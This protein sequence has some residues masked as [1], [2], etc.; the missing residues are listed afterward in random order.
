MQSPKFWYNSPGHPGWQARLLAPIGRVYAAATARRVAAAKGYQSQVPVV[1][2]GN[3]NIGGTGKTPSVIALAQHLLE[4]G[5]NPHV[6][7]RGY[8]GTLTGPVRVDEQ[9]H[10]ASE[11]G[12][13]PLLIA[14]FAPVW[15][16]DNRADGV[17]AA[18]KAGADIIILDDGFQSPAVHYDMS[19]IVVDAVRGFG[20]GRCLPAGPLREPVQAGM[21]RADMVLSIG[22]KKA[23]DGFRKAWGGQIPVPHVTGELTPLPTGF[24]WAGQDVIAFAGI[25]HPEKFFATLRDLGANVVR[26]EALNDHQVLSDALLTRLEAEALLCDAQLVTTEKDAVRLPA[27]FRPKVVTLP[28]RLELADWRPI[29]DHLSRLGVLGAAS[30]PSR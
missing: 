3:L 7:S 20:N 26:A 17:R 5:G 8:G 14:A 29:D 18:E 4:K 16:A 2:I 9:A 24:D 19:I 30:S 21:K 23:Q 27:A 11:T 13:E 12:D 25:G 10:K 28:V 15:V 6:V 22:S 1:C